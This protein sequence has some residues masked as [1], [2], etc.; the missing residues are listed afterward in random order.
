VRPAR[1]AGSGRHDAAM[2]QLQIREVC[3]GGLP[4]RLTCIQ[5]GSCT[6]HAARSPRSPLPHRSHPQH[7]TSVLDKQGVL[8]R[9]KVGVMVGWGACCKG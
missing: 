8:S 2:D 5:P 4:A 9:I 6:L 7:V 3:L 1:L